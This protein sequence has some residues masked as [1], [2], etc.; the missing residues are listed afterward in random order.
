MTW[1]SKRTLNCSKDK[2]YFLHYFTAHSHDRRQGG[3]GSMEEEDSVINDPVVCVGGC[4]MS[5]RGYNYLSSLLFL[6]RWLWFAV[7][8][9]YTR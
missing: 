7:K 1:P 2:N 9:S 5:G 4:N 3:S 6:F 8:E